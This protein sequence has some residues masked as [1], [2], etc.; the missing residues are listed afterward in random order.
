MFI[1][2][3]SLTYW[4][5]CFNRNTAVTDLNHR[6]LVDTVIVWHGASDEAVSL[7]GLEG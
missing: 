3:K 1:I 4:V 6:L 5:L 2:P 7:Q